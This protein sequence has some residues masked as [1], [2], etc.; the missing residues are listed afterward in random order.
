M[1]KEQKEELERYKKMIPYLQNAS[2]AFYSASN[3]RDSYIDYKMGRIDKLTNST[4][5]ELKVLELLEKLGYS[6]DEVGTYFYKDLILEVYRNLKEKDKTNLEETLIDKF[7]QLYYYIATEDKEIGIK[8]FH[9]YIEKAVD[10]IDS[11]STDKELKEKIY[12]DK[13]IEQYGLNA[14]NIASYLDQYQLSSKKKS[15]KSSLKK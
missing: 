15:R 11:S 9:S 4:L 3:D 12:G 8:S 10:E 14:L 13:S 7:S 5:I 1:K 6:M 2:Y